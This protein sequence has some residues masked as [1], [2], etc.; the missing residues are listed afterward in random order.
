M[1]TDAQPK[2]AQRTFHRPSTLADGLAALARWPRTD[3]VAGGTDLIVAAR[4]GKRALQDHIVA[5][6]GLAELRGMQALPAGGI[7]FGAITT[8]AEI[9]ASSA[10]RDRYTA[11]ADASAVVGSPATRANGTLGGN[12]ANGSP[13]MET[14]S[15]LLIFD[16]TVRLASAEGTRTM[17]VA[18]FLQ[19]PGRT[20]RR[21]DELIVGV[22]V[23][24]LPEGR[25]GSAYVR[26]EYRQA[27][28]IAVVGVAA[29][30][31]L[32]EAGHIADGRLALTAVAPTCLRATRAESLLAG[33][34]AAPETFATAAAASATEASPIGDLRAD[35]PYRREMIAVFAERALNLAQ[36]RTRGVT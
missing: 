31:V 27:M 1:S 25:I 28:E 18:E 36:T 6:D 17:P 19:G 23:P 14:G 34:R 10:V 30:V 35:E 13:A 4:S 33:K 20:A 11:L 22:D 3:V 8:H 26:L 15:P 7:A 12:L 2:P 9:A 32:D 16:A 21:D 24:P 29:M 5:I